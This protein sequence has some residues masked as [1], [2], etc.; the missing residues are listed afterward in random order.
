MPNFEVENLFL[1]GRNTVFVDYL[2]IQFVHK[3]PPCL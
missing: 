3:E 2:L 1:K